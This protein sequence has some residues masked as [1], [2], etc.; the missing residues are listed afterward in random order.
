MK[1]EVVKLG[2]GLSAAVFMWEEGDQVEGQVEL[3]NKR[4]VIKSFGLQDTFEVEDIV[5][6]RIISK[7]PENVRVVH[8][9]EPVAGIQKKMT[10]SPKTAMVKE[11]IK[12][13][14]P[15]L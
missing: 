2:S 15:Q 14:V 12:K 13:D 1:L 3:K 6:H 10:S 5:G 8:Y 7:Y 9:G 4:K 11:E